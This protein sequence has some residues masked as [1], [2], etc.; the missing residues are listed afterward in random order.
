MCECVREWWNI[1]RYKPCSF[2]TFSIEFV[3]GKLTAR[4]KIKEISIHIFHFLFDA[5]SMSTTSFLFELSI[6]VR[7]RTFIYLLL[8]YIYD[9]NTWNRIIIQIHNNIKT[10]RQKK[11]QQEDECFTACGASSVSMYRK[12][13]N[14]IEFWKEKKK[15]PN[16][17]VKRCWRN[18][19]CSNDRR[20]MKIVPKPIDFYACIVWSAFKICWW[21]CCCCCSSLLY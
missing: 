4:P 9:I 14:E 5:F 3:C 1:K 8:V 13:Q 2:S 12:N 15:K 7:G 21:C 6:N 11:K 16:W 20:P 10:Y 19:S 18:P 17:I